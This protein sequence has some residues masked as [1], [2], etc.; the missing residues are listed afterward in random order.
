V[1]NDFEDRLRAA[2]RAVE[3]EAGFTERVLARIAT[4]PATLAK[5]RARLAW[6]SAALAATVVLGV[7]AVH[8]WQLR[9]E[10]QGLEARR[11]LIEALRVASDK[12]DITY[13]L[14]NEPAPAAPAPSGA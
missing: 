9:R 4:E 6:A 12:L 3:P 10:Q 2:L 8:Q 7:L 13:H 14:V 5:P 1:N 11:E